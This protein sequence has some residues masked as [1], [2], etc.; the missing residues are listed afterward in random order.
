MYKDFD[1]WNIHKKRINSNKNNTLYHQRD[2]W[3]CS[4]G[5]NVGFEEDGKG[6]K[7]LRPV[8]IVHGFSR[9]LCWAIPL[10]TSRKQNLYYISVGVINGKEQSVILSQM[11]PVDTRRLLYKISYLED[12]I[13]FLKIKQVVKDILDDLFVCNTPNQAMTE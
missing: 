12:E 7:A 6:H 2:I 11:K 8:L 1:R 4:L 3:W 5:I 13:C 9:E 10:T